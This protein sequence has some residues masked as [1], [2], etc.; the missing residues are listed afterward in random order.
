MRKKIS[1]FVIIWA[2]KKVFKVSFASVPR[3]MGLKI[4]LDFSSLKKAAF[5]IYNLDMRLFSETTY[6]YSV[7][8]ELSIDA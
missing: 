6:S 4:G 3:K 1:S 2:Y 8:W 7:W 5:V